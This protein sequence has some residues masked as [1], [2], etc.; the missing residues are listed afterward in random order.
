M[1]FAVGVG[2][3]AVLTCNESCSGRTFWLY[4]DR[5]GTSRRN[6]HCQFAAVLRTFCPSCGFSIPA[7]KLGWI[8][9]TQMQCPKCEHVFEAGKPSSRKET[10]YGKRTRISWASRLQREHLF[11]ALGN[12]RRNHRT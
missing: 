3:A 6:H 12:E 4:S 8:D 5:L 9:F 1:P 7:D 11:P 2:S 10:V